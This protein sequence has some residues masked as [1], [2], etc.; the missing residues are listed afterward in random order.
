MKVIF[1]LAMPEPK[2][3]PVISEFIF[4]PLLLRV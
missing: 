3:V 2:M 1:M 4:S